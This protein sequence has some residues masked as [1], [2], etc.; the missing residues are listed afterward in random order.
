MTVSGARLGVPPLIASVLIGINVLA[1][2]VTAGDAGSFNE[3]QNGKLF[4]EFALIPGNVGAG[5]WWG[6]LT[7]GFL[8]FGVLHLSLNMLNLALIGPFVES[9]LGRLRTLSVY[10]ASGLCGSLLVSLIPQEQPGLFLGASGCIMGLLGATAGI[11]LHGH[12]SERS[13]T[14]RGRLQRLAPPLLL[15]LAFDLSV[16][17]ISLTAHWSG[18]FV[19]LS[20]GHLFQRRVRALAGTSSQRIG[21]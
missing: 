18:V 3:P 1:Y 15:Q 21:S 19:G 12:R 5:H 16:P 10:L 14:A 9:S 20:L 17:G 8:H 13:Q 11:L 6:V 2:I 4:F 7:A